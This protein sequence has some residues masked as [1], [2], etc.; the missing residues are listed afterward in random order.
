MRKLKVE[1]DFGKLTSPCFLYR[2]RYANMTTTSWVSMVSIMPPALILVCTFIRAPL[3]LV[4]VVIVL[5]ANVPRL[6]SA[7][8]VDQ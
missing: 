8:A 1:K 7:G 3:M 4:T 2:A 6:N 5:A